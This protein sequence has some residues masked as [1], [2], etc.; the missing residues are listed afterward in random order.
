MGRQIRTQCRPIRLRLGFRSAYLRFRP[1]A[2]PVGADTIAVGPRPRSC[3]AGYGVPQR[4]VC[5]SVWCATVDGVELSWQI[6]AGNGSL[7]WGGVRFHDVLP[8]SSPWED[9]LHCVLQG[10]IQAPPFCT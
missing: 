3:G 2:L 9:D 5:H 10:Q 6:A 4:M 7:S 1:S 8:L